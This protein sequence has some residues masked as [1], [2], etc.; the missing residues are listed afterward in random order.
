[1]W[2][3]KEQISALETKVAKHQETDEELLLAK[4]KLE[5]QDKKLRFARLATEQRLKEDLLKDLPAENF[6]ADPAIIGVLAST[7]NEDDFEFVDADNQ[8]LRSR[9]GRDHYLKNI[10]SDLDLTNPEHVKKIEIVRRNI[11]KKIKMTRYSKIRHRSRIK[12]PGQGSPVL[13]PPPKMSGIPHL[14]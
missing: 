12:W 2:Q 7:L 1:M 10:E 6:S 9:K 3:L 5:H 13:H 11:L 8:E 4:E 14:K